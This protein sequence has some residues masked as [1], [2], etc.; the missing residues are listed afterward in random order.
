MR[1]A[2]ATLGCALLALLVGL[3][4]E[5]ETSAA[6]RHCAPVVTNAGPGLTKATVIIV[7]G[8]VDCEKSRKVIFKA[9]SA[10]SY[11]HRT[12]NG[13]D[14]ES[15][16]RASASQLFGA[17]CTTEGDV[18]IETIKS[19]VPHRCPDCNGIKN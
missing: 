1:I 9:L 16:K 10:T 2:T 13:W 19:T 8:R 14:C 12:I 7:D 11:K 3:S 18:E 5:A 17:R 6:A 4:F 15:T